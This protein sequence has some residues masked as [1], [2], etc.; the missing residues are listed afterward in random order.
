MSSVVLIVVTICYIARA[1]STVLRTSTFW[2]DFC[3]T[4]YEDG[5]NNSSYGL[6]SILSELCGHFGEMTKLCMFF[7]VN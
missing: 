2:V 4:V 6:E 1:R 7:T 5:I 3:S